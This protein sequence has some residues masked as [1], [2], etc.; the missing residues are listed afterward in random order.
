[1]APMNRT[2]VPAAASPESNL[3][4]MLL[5]TKMTL[6]SVWISV[7]GGAAE[8]MTARA[9]RDLACIAVPGELNSE[10]GKTRIG[11]S[12]CGGGNAMTDL[13]ARIEELSDEDAIGALDLVLRHQS[14]GAGDIAIRAEEEERQFRQAL[15]EPEARRELE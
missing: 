10:G 6:A 7:A 5:W 9:P 11:T 13:A 15:A 8:I 14:P 1:M 2:P 3:D 4:G 12:R